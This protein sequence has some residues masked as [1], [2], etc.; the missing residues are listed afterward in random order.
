ME[1]IWIKKE[2]HFSS[3]K[4]LKF[5]TFSDFNFIFNE[6]LMISLLLKSRKRGLFTAKPPSQRGARG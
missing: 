1:K 4:F 6:F 5:L 3:Y 2:L